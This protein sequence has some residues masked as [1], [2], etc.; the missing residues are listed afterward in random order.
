MKGASISNIQQGISKLQGKDAAQSIKRSC[1]EC[2]PHLVIGYS[3]LDIGYFPP[4]RVVHSRYVF[5]VHIQP[6]IY[7]YALQAHHSGSE[8]HRR[9]EGI[10][11]STTSSIQR[12]A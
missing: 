9:C 3:L 11:R 12:F 7:T 4:T 5:L 1:K 6:V 8:R 10:R 2:F